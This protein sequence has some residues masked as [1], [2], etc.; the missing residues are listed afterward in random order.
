[1]SVEL[2]EME[3]S[4]Y[5]M[6]IARALVALGVPYESK[7]VP[8]WDRSAVIRLTEGAYYQVSMLVH[9]EEM[10]IESDSASID[11]ARYVDKAFGEGRLFPEK[12]KGLHEILIDFIKIDLELTTFKLIDPYYLDTIEDLAKYGRLKA[13][14]Y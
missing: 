13:F 7:L 10:V 12:N 11:I 1:M 3:H 4:P 6:P 8:N 9:G 2:Y 5:C 14:G